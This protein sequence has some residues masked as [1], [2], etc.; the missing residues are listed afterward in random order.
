[1]KDPLKIPQL[2]L[3]CALGITFLTPVSDRLGILG[4]KGTGNVEWGNWQNFINYTSTLMPLFDRPVV[5]ILGGIA[6]VTELIIAILLI[7]G[8]RTRNASAAASLIT[9]TF[10]VFMVLSVGI[11]KPINY[12][13][14]TATTAGFLLARVPNYEWSIDR[15]L[16]KKSG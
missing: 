11:Q 8:Y 6:T 12:G 3:R 10:I 1:M 9:L 2:L 13:V 7:I 5:N 14:F 15:L 4:P 16:A